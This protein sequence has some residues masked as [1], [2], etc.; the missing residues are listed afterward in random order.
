MSVDAQRIMDLIPYLH[1]LWSGPFQIGLALYFLYQEMGPSIFAGLGVMVAMIPVNAFLS[2]RQ[3]KYQKVQMKNKDNRMKLIEESLSGIKVIKLYAWEPA[4][5]LKIENV[6][7]KELETLK[8]IGYLSAIQSFTWSCTPFMVCFATFA[9]YCVIGEEPFDA[10]KIFVS[11]SLF[12]MLQFPL[13]MFPMVIASVVE[14]SVALKRL[15]HFLMSEELDPEAVDRLDVSS[16]RKEDPAIRAPG[17]SFSWLKDGEIILHDLN[18]TL[19]KGQ[20]MGVVGKVGSGKSSILSAIL[21]EMYRVDTD[22]DLKIAVRGSLAFVGQQAWIMNATLRENIL[23]GKQYDEQL[24]QTTID[25]CGLRPD[26]EMLPGGDLTEIGERGINLSGGQKQRISF[27]R[28]VYAQADIYLLDDP[29]SAV[30]AHVGRHIFNSVIG[31]SGLLKNKARFFVTHAIQF[32]PECDQIMMVNGGRIVE[33]P[34]SFRTLMGMKENGNVWQLVNEFIET[35]A[36]SSDKEE[37][38][39]TLDELAEKA[40]VRLSSSVQSAKSNLSVLSVRK[41]KSRTPTPATVLKEELKNQTSEPVTQLMVKEET[42]KGSVSK[43]V[44]WSYVK[45]CSWPAVVATIIM[46]IVGQLTTTGSDVWLERWGSHPESA[47]TWLYLGVYGS[48]GLLFAILVVAQVIFV[49]VFCA[50]RSSR[51][52]HHDLLMSIMHEPMWF[53]DTTPLGRIV[54]RFS[55]DIYTVDEVLPRSFM[56]Y[57]RTLFS[58]IAIIFVIIISTPLFLLFVIPM[59]KFQR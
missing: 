58:V 12:N 37:D 22:G 54:N 35:R 6:R 14:A 29:L 25:A 2:T 18:F 4:F 49:W 28:A 30:D 36:E 19:K 10:T 56:S 42:A 31:S 8:S 38:V 1:I 40:G 17:V 26:M 41:E 44:Y 47:S 16:E 24:Y 27:A 20:L 45:A 21:G 52:L 39:I 3:R 46:M 48:F 15:Y 9:L 34:A 51:V 5:Q 59:G 13:N 53:F 50:I 23:F 33:G 32:L 11:L 55:K 43:D 7:K 57:F